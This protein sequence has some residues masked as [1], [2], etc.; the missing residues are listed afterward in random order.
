MSERNR[1]TI[2]A[3]NVEGIFNMMILSNEGHT[4]IDKPGLTAVEVC[5]FLFSG[6]LV[7]F[8]EF[9]V[10]GKAVNHEA[11]HAEAHRRG[12]S[13]VSQGPCPGCGRTTSADPSCPVCG[14]PWPSA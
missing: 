12:K 1:A 8:L 7:D 10:D 9:D 11:I 2:W 3:T 14:V 4:R 6:P 5:D 13:I